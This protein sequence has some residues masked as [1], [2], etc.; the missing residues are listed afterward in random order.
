MCYP[1]PASGFCWLNAP[2]EAS[3][4]RLRPLFALGGASARASPHQAH[5]LKAWLARIEL[6]VAQGTERSRSRSR[7]QPGCLQI[8]VRRRTGQRAAH[9]SRVAKANQVTRVLRKDSRA[10][11]PRAVFLSRKPSEAKKNVANGEKV[12]RSWLNSVG[13][14][15]QAQGGVK[16]LQAIFCAII[17]MP[18]WQP[19]WPIGSYAKNFRSRFQS[20]SAGH[21]REGALHSELLQQG[22]RGK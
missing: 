7:E 21:G 4:P 13:P 3:K 12:K 8:L 17:I 11:H 22:I 19:P 1:G 18:D 14:G 15:A 2:E 20:A 16:G 10:K 9:E 6:R 5:Q